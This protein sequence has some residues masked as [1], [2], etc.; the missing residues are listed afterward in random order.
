M[1]TMTITTR[2]PVE[3]WLAELGLD[4]TEVEACPV[5]ECE[6]CRPAPVVAA[7]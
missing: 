3:Q 5:A 4:A 2:T 7:A 1:T 6:L